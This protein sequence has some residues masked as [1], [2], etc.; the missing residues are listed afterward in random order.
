MKS[1]WYYR[2]ALAI[3][4]LPIMAYAPVRAYA[5]E[6]IPKAIQQFIIDH[7]NASPEE[8]Q[9][10]AK[11][12]TPQFASQFKNIDD[13][14][15]IVRNQQTSWWDNAWDFI[16]LGVKHI[17]GGTDH[18]LFVLSLLLAFNTWKDIFKLT[19]TFTV[20]HSI[21]LVLAGLSILTLPSRIVEPTIAFSIAFVALSTVLLQHSKYAQW[22]HKKL[23]VVFFFGLFHGLGFAGLLQELRIPSEKFALSLF[24]FN[25]GIE[26]GQLTIVVIAVPL[27]LLAKRYR[28]FPR[29]N[30]LAGITLGIIGLVWGVQRMIG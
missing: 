8:I 12:E 21:T 30:T 17:L 5:H 13:L 19:S 10:F 22:I 4:L 20:A 24:S 16:K 28:W 25:V 18:I 6:L 7:P 29:A 9:T 11:A 26:I 27:I 23:F 15:K 14:M 3:A 1:L 2:A